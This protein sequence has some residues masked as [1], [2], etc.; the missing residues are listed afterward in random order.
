[1]ELIDRGF[2]LKRRSL[3]SDTCAIDLVSFPG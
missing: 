3:N 1:M 2:E